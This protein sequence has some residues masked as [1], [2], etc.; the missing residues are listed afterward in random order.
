MK[1]RYSIIMKQ[2]STLHMEGQELVCILER[3]FKVVILHLECQNMYCLSDDW[4]LV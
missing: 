4:E 2:S 1:E 3:P